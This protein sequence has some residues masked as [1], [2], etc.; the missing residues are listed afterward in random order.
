M[1]I[2]KINA[3][4]ITKQK[5]LKVAAYARVSTGKDAA[6]HSLDS[7]IDYYK[8]YIGNHPNW[9]YVGIYADKAISGT[10]DDRPEFQRL[11]RD[12]IDGKIDLILTKSITRLARNTLTLLSTTRELKRLGIDVYFEKEK[13]HSIGSDGEFLITCL[14]LY[15]EEEARTASENKKWQFQKDFANGRLR[16]LNKLYGYDVKDGKYVINESEADIVK[17]VFKEYLDGKG[18]NA[19]SKDLNS[20]GIKTISGGNWWEKNIFNMIRNEKYTGDMILQK[21]YRRDFRDKTKRL[22]EGELR[23]YYV[24]GTHE[25]I[26]SHAD[27]DAVQA[28]IA[29]RGSNPKYHN[30][31]EKSPISGLLRCKKCGSN[32]TRCRNHIGEPGEYF[33]WVCPT[34]RKKGKKVCD[35]SQIRED[36]LITK[37]CEA[38]KLKSLEGID[39]REYI[40]HIDIE[41]HNLIFY[42]TDG[43]QIATTYEKRNK[44]LAWTTEKREQASERMKL[45]RRKEYFK[46]ES[47]R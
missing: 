25:A 45:R 5:T 47:K 2:Q 16:T 36:I 40:D 24:E 27:F 10:K 31:R 22:N 8:K 4:K 7:Q 35:A 19:I 17:Y 21:T 37:I 18:I 23:R 44:S 30:K 15:A 9:E 20:K 14:A 43:K 32:F 11:I 28:E 33:A 3:T 13:M 38:T 39:L 42:L 34:Y 46:Y 6:F 41:D 26:I 29:R 1:E 12:A